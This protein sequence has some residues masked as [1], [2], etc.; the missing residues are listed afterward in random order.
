MV[1]CGHGPCVCVSYIPDSLLHTLSLL[2]TLSLL[3][4]LCLASPIFSLVYVSHDLVCLFHMSSPFSL[5]HSR[6]LFCSFCVSCV[7]WCMMALESVSRLLC[8]VACE[9]EYLWREGC[10]DIVGMY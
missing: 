4:T 5:V 2:F 8:L 6:F 3:Y 10:V 7:W 9:R 1:L